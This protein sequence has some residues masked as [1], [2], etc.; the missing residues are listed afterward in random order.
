VAFGPRVSDLPVD[1]PALQGGAIAP[2][3]HTEHV[4]RSR[5]AQHWPLANLDLA[6]FESALLE[7]MFV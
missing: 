4:G 2:I 6:E 1:F 7:E 5:V 3:V